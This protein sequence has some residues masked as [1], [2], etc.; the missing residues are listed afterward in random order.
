MAIP[1]LLQEA[2]ELGDIEGCELLMGQIS[3]ILAEPAV[4]PP[5]K[6]E[7]YYK[8]LGQAYRDND[9]EFIEGREEV[10]EDE[11]MQATDTALSARSHAGDWGQSTDPA[12]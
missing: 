11:E 12:R 8:A 2:I 1:A 6:Y 9:D 7:A 10:L 5:A 3:Q 4:V